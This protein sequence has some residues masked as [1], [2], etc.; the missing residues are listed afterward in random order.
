M[1]IPVVKIFSRRRKKRISYGLDYMLND[2]RIRE[3]VAHDKKNAEIIR[4]QR[5]NELTLG[6]MEYDH[7]HQKSYHLK[8]YFPII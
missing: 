1:K 7:L 6:S 2:K 4:G 3:I 5:Q 8:N